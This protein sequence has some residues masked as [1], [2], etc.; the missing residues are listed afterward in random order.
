MTYFYSQ[1]YLFSLFDMCCIL[2]SA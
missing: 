2:R 1:T